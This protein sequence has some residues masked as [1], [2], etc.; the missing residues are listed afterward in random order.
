[1]G[2]TRLR[3]LISRAYRAFHRHLIK[4]F[5]LVDY[6]CLTVDL[7][8][9]NHKCFMGTTA[10]W[11]DKKTLK[12]KSAAISCRRIMGINYKITNSN[13]LLN[14]LLI[15]YLFLGKHSFDVLAA[16][17]HA[18]ISEFKL[19]GKVNAIVTDNGSN[20]VRAFKEHGG[21]VES[22]QPA[23]ESM[24][25]FETDEEEPFDY[26]LDEASTL[27]AHDEYTLSFFN[28]EQPTFS[29]IEEGLSATKPAQSQ[30]K[31]PSSSNLIDSS[32]S[33]E[34]EEEEEEQNHQTRFA[35]PPHF[36]CASHTLN[37]LG[38]TDVDKIMKGD[39]N[40]VH[41]KSFKKLQ[42]FWTRINKSNQAAESSF[43]AFGM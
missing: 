37:L 2:A 29:I 15:K 40:D 36:R 31:Q 10:H 34:E 33:E 26:D 3:R 39:G 9:A 18:L 16:H 12:R 4:E 8:T 27:P 13:K 24:T 21:R 41:K 5:D 1:M 14:R 22:P 25:D 23:E 6:I 32:E 20:F 42:A 28:K 11:L 35:L 38:T 30:S 17:I 7:W 43:K 19:Q